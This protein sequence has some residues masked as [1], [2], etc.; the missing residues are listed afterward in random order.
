MMTYLVSFFVILIIILTPIL[1]IW[2]FTYF[3][4]LSYAAFISKERFDK[5]WSIDQEN[6]K[7]G[8]QMI[9]GLLSTTNGKSHRRKGL[10]FLFRLWVSEYWC[11]ETK[12]QSADIYK[13]FFHIPHKFMTYE[14]A[15][16]L[17]K[18]I[19]YA[20]YYSPSKPN[21]HKKYKEAS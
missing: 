18:S 7:N 21:R 19:C 8:T 5:W 13:K 6:F 9:L 1:Y 15:N 11:S 2:L 12:E 17:F 4:L 3:G 14:D 10:V 20:L 16:S